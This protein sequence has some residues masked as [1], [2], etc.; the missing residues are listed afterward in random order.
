GRAQGRLG[1]RR[2][3]AR[4]GRPA[5]LGR[6]RRGPAAAR[7]PGRGGAGPAAGSVPARRA[8]VLRAAGPRAGCRAGRAAA[9]AGGHATPRR[10]VPFRPVGEMCAEW[11]RIFET[12]YGICRAL[13]RDQVDP[14]LAR[15]AMDLFR[16]LPAAA[17]DTV[18]LATDLHHGNVLASEREPWLAIDPKPY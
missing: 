1:A 13:G 9:A 3:R 14:G 15:A 8:A 16:G 10:G 17:P 5:R 7:A 4:G 6:R 12:E 11:A 2:G 18:L